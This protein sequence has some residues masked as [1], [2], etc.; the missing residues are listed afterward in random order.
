MSRHSDGYVL[1]MSVC[2]WHVTKFFRENLVAPLD[3]IHVVGC[4]RAVSCCLKD[5][6][7]FLSLAV[8]HLLSFLSTCT[9]LVQADSSFT[10]RLH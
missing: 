2:A 10:G 1:R 9:N 4:N 6:S 3:R 5:I 7:E 8:C